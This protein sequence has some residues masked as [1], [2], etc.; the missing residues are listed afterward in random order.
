MSVFVVVACQYFDEVCRTL[1]EVLDDLFF[2][3]I[4]FPLSD[5]YTRIVIGNAFCQHL[6][7]CHAFPRF[8]HSGHSKTKLRCVFQGTWGLF[9]RRLNS[10]TSHAITGFDC[11]Y[12]GR[13]EL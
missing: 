13:F 3:R 5:M 2:S 12:G 10:E 7:V 9:L 4:H 6:L 11:D 8:L 1:Q